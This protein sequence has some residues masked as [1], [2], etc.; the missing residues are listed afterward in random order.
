MAEK[1]ILAT[2]KGKKIDEYYEK[3]INAGDQMVKD[4]DSTKL[5]KEQ[6]DEL[7]K[8]IDEGANDDEKL[9]VLNNLP[10][11]NGVKERPNVAVMEDST[12]KKVKVTVD[13]LT[14]ASNIVGNADDDMDKVPPINLDEYLDMSK[15]EKDNI[16]IN[17][18]MI[19]FDEVKEDYG[20]SKEETVAI[21][22]LMKR[23][24]AGEDF[25][26]YAELKHISP[27][28]ANVINKAG[29]SSG[30]TN[31]SM[32]KDFINE[33]ILDICVN[34]FTID[35]NEVIDNEIR[36]TAPDLSGM[37]IDLIT[38]KKDKLNNLADNIDAEDH[39][40]AEQ[41]REIAKACE[42]SYTYSGFKEALASH[43]IKIKKYEIERPDKVF[44]N[45]CFK[46]QN[47]KLAINQVA[48][49]VLCIPRHFKESR[50]EV[51][52]NEITRDTVIAFAVAFCNYCMN[53]KV[54]NNAQH[55]FMY[56]FI[57]NILSMD[58]VGS[59]EEVS[60]FYRDLV[61]N[62]V[63]CLNIIHEKYGY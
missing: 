38:C 52:R 2:G 49:I 41:L 34:S 5:T 19:N 45:F 13:P 16:D 54:T 17:E 20:L 8:L 33:M 12:E 29:K 26:V 23:V 31:E 36:N 25:D 24:Q 28:I 4:A 60:E 35:V 1:E 10:S 11:S 22:P 27:K 39:G 14:G 43:K 32:A 53:F 58:I 9:R 21:I 57:R 40:K 42:E 50:I 56:Y 46:Y 18:N 15:Y 3:L 51:D 6:V 63:E 44:N 55:M 7:A 30:I 59:G 47:T 48:D 62:I 61:T 37:Y